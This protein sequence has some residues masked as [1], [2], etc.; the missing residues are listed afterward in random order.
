MRFFLQ[1]TSLS[2]RA[3]PRN[4]VETNAAAY[5]QLYRHS[6]LNLLQKNKKNNV[7]KLVREN[8]YL[9]KTGGKAAMAKNNRPYNAKFARER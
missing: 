3:K 9:I 1:T 7:Y 2:F 5:S 6:E 8:I 4:L